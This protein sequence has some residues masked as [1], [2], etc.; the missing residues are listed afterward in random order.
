[1]ATVKGVIF[2]IDDTLYFERDYVR[3]GFQAVA[4]Y[5]SCYH[6]ID[7]Q[8]AFSFLW[9]C[10]QTGKRGNTFDLLIEATPGL[11][12]HVTPQ[13]LV[14]I[15]RSHQPTINIIPEMANLMD[16]LQRMGIPMGVISDGPIEAQSHK[17]EAL[18]LSRWMKVICLTDQWGKAYWKPHPRA[19]EA[20][21]KELNLSGSELVYVADNAKKDFEAPSRR[22]WH[23]IHLQYSNTLYNNSQ[24]PNNSI[25]AAPS[26]KACRAIVMNLVTNHSTLTSHPDPHA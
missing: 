3:S 13:D 22:G 23:M 15:Y 8:T 2:D 14:M 9:A 26:H 5:L 18:G 1:M 4:N 17:V 20:C 24:H 21:E 19:Y 10:F 16:D 7:S 11:V 12:P 25:I 6:A